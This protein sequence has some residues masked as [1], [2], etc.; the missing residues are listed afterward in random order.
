LA[1]FALAKLQ[2]R[3]ELRVPKR[4]RAHHHEYSMSWWA[5]FYGL[6]RC[7]LIYPPHKRKSCAESATN[8]HDGQIT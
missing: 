4:Q 3:V 7:G 2:S 8:W 6:A 5:R 1:L